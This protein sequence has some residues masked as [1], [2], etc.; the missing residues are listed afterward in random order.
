MRLNMSKSHL[1]KVFQLKPFS[2]VSGGNSSMAIGTDAV[3]LGTWV[4][5]PPATYNVVDVGCGCGII[6]L[7]L[8]Y[9]AQ[10]LNILG[11]DINPAAIET[12]MTNAARTQYGH[13]V[14]FA[15][16]DVRLFTSPRV[17]DLVVSN[18]PFFPAMK[19]KASVP[20]TIQRT[21]A[22]QGL[23]L[24]SEE[25]IVAA[26]RLT[27]PRGQLAVII[28]QSEAQDFEFL[29]AMN[30]FHLLRSTE[31]ITVEGKRPKRC[32]MQ[33]QKTLAPQTQIR[34]SITLFSHSGEKT[35]Q[36]TKLTQDFYL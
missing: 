31:V 2:L 21:M 23:F 27:T 14:S 13:N 17:A 22:R 6:A 36:Y 30:D 8:A 7:M 10:Q 12:A 19:G 16:A 35:P 15:C 25:L 1:S 33:F 11:L 32:L 29:A 34:D 9:R 28:P 20:L 24:S 5:I 26:K 4:N 18:P 3:L